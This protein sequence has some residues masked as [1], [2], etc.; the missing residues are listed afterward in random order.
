MAAKET[1]TIR[2]SGKSFFKSEIFLKTYHILRHP[3]IFNC[4]SFIPRFCT[5]FRTRYFIFSFLRKTNIFYLSKSFLE[6]IYKQR[7]LLL[8]HVVFSMTRTTKTEII[9]PIF[10]V[11]FIMKQCPFVYRT[12]SFA[13]R[14]LTKRFTSVFLSQPIVN[15]SILGTSSPLLFKILHSYNKSLIQE[16]KNYNE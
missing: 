11:F 13:F 10:S 7:N 3:W 9:I 16:E 1:A 2:E 8:R 6:I 14:R 15:R 5:F 12:F 4:K